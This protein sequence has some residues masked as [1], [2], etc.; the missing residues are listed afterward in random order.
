MA[1]LRL[2]RYLVLLDREPLRARSRSIATRRARDD[3]PLTGECT[4]FQAGD[5][6]PVF[7]NG[8]DAGRVPLREILL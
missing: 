1:A 7:I 6:V 5:E 2:G 4:T 8:R 3:R